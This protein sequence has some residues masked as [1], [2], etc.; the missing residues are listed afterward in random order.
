M[1]M[2]NKGYKKHVHRRGH[3]CN[4]QRR[5]RVRAPLLQCLQMYRDL[6][7]NEYVPYLMRLRMRTLRQ[8]AIARPTDIDVHHVQELMTMHDHAIDCMHACCT[9]FEGSS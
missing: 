9:E 3:T 5:R 1:I 7:G 2:I 4:P 8:I 6:T